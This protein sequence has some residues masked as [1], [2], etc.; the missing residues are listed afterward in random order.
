M[1]IE[2]QL[3]VLASHKAQ[4]DKHIKQHINHDGSLRPLTFK[5]FQINV[6][7]K[8]NQ[9]CSHCHVNASPKRTEMMDIKTVNACL[10]VI[11]EIPDIETVDITGGAP[12]MN[13]N[14][15]YLVEESVKLKKHVIDRC[16]LT[17]LEYPGFEYLYDFLSSH[18][19]EMVASL[20]HFSS[21]FTDHQRG[22]GVF[23][24]S[25]TALE[26]LNRLGYGKDKTLNLVYNPI[27]NFLSAPQ[28]Q[29]EREFKENLKRRF[30]IVFNNLYC[31]NNLPINRY[32]TQ[33][34]KKGRFESYMELLVNSFNPATLDGL[35]CRHQ[36]SV[37]YDGKV[38]DCDFNQMLE[39]LIP[40]FGSIKE[41]DYDKFINRKI[42]I[43]NHCF[44][45]TA[46]SGSS[47]SGEIASKEETSEIN[48]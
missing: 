28:K 46:G 2:K 35:M 18:N 24:L 6:G 30:N 21:S 20:P 3:E 7:A 41:F 26:K 14:F 42:I 15:R 11:S 48:N 9:T 31:I 43:A 34:Q 38:Y 27:G 4:F 44:G 13:V 22:R 45:C 37:G 33:L 17:I 32:L 10:K 16:N 1:K 47:C 12:E 19:V 5:T 29:L 25:I 40:S 39:L 36:I 23:E 8:C